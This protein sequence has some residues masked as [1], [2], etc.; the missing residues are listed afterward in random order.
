MNAEQSLIEN[1]EK[2][3]M[4]SEDVVEIAN[5]LLEVEEP[6]FDELTNNA[7]ILASYLNEFK[8][9]WDN[10][11]YNGD[12]D[13]FA[14][15]AVDKFKQILADI[16]A[17]NVYKKIFSAELAYSYLENGNYLY[18]LFRDDSTIY[19]CTILVQLSLWLFCKL[20]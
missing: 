4:S 14:S 5:N 20:E 16:K 3:L 11:S 18:I 2:S 13:E 17:G 7:E 8:F 6:K 19:S 12:S 9:D 1:I 10:E 15:T